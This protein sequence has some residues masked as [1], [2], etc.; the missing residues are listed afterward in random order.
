VVGHHHDLSASLAALASSAQSVIY[1][2]DD[3]NHEALEPHI[4]LQLHPLADKIFEVVLSSFCRSL[5]LAG[6]LP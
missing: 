1:F 6:P 2:N 4:A 3:A 5:A